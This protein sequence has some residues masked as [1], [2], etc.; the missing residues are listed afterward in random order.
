MVCFIILHV[1]RLPEIML[2]VL[3]NLYYVTI[4][5][6]Y[7]PFGEADLRFPQFINVIDWQFNSLQHSWDLE[8]LQNDLF[9]SSFPLL[10]R[11]KVWLNFKKIKLDKVLGKNFFLMHYRSLEKKYQ[12]IVL[13][14]FTSFMHYL[15][16]VCMQV[17]GAG[18]GDG[19]LC[20]L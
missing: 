5:Q 13:C 10:S 12:R 11:I 17:G 20:D 4:L 3:S 7:V 16:G 8:T 19:F 1:N 6:A 2:N 15:Q 9:I 14:S 18:K